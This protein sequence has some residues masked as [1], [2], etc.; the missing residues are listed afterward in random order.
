MQAILA[1]V[2][3]QQPVAPAPQPAPPPAPRSRKPRARRTTKRAA[4]GTVVEG[5]WVTLAD[6]RLGRV[7]HVMTE[8]VLNLGDIEMPATADDPVALVS[9]WS[10]GEFDDP[11]GVKIVDVTKAEKPDGAV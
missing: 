7:D 5:D 8:G 2:P 3:D 9:T 10:E 11:V 6:G 1:G 4:P